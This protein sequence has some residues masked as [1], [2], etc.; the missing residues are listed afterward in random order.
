L[1]GKKRYID[2]NTTPAMAKVQDFNTYVDS[3][4]GSKSNN[5][6]LKEGFMDSLANA[7]DSLMPFSK[8]KTINYAID[9]ILEYEKDLLNELYKFKKTTRSLELK[10]QDV[11]GRTPPNP[12]AVNSI[13]DEIESRNKEYKALVKS[14]SIA[15]E[16]AK[17]LLKREAA[18]TPRL[19][20]VIKAKMAE[21]E[22]E[23]AEF[24]YD[25][26]K[27]V[28]AETSDIQ[29]LKDTI[30]KAKKEAQELIT[31]LTAAPTP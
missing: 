19:K 24:E 14:K 10:L 12:D 26:A 1:F 18:K 5:S 25:L 29:N 31:K 23:L 22:I 13:R 7:I 15:I 27:K 11:R 16:K 8:T 28:S 21:M 30:E 9:N 6:H 2:K 3:H 20:E 17:E 4:F